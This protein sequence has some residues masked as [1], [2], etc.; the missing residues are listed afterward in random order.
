VGAALL[1]K[2]PDQRVY[3]LCVAECVPP[4]RPFASRQVM[5]H[6]KDGQEQAVTLIDY[7]SLPSPKMSNPAA[8]LRCCLLGHDHHL[9]PVRVGGSDPDE[10]LKWID[11]VKARGVLVEV[12]DVDFVDWWNGHISADG[13]KLRTSL[14]GGGWG[15]KPPAMATSTG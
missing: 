11:S 13:R 8:A 9:D 1:R 2:H 12:D 15:F 14:K 7:L 10:R 3:E 4:A 6:R 5:V